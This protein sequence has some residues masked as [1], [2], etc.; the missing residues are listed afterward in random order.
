[1]NGFRSLSTHLAGFGDGRDVGVEVGGL[2]IEL[3]QEGADVVEQRLAGVSVPHLGELAQVAQLE[4]ASLS[5]WKRCS[6]RLRV[7]SEG[8]VEATRS[9]Y[10]R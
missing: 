7:H 3:Q 5:I 2:R 10:S 6:R 4:A 8:T 1:M 9:P